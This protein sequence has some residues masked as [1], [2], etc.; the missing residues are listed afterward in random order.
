MTPEA[1]I[2]AAVD[3]LDRVLAGEPAERSLTTWARGNRFAG[4]RD[5]AAIRDHVYDALRRR[6]SALALSGQ[7]TSSGRALMIGLLREDGGDP[8]TVF[9]GQGYAPAP[10]SAQEAE[11]LSSAPVRGDLPEA[12]SLDLPDWLVAPL[13]ARL[14]DDFGAAMEAMRHR[15]PVFLRV[16][17]AR[18][19]RE[20]AAEA[21]AAEGIST[22]HSPLAVHALEVIDGA[23]RI[24]SSQSYL[25]GLVEL[26]DAASQAAVESLPLT[27][28]MRVLDYC[29]GGGGKV[30]AMAAR[31]QGTWFAHDADPR[32]MADLPTRA[33]RAGVAVRRIPTERVAVEAP[34]DLVL[35]DVPCTGSGTWR[36]TPEAKWTLR[37]ERLEELTRTQDDILSDAQALVR[38]GGAL[39][40]MT[41]SLLE[42]EN[43][44]R[45]AAFLMAHPSFE[46]ETERRFSPL[47]GGD[48]FYLAC[49]R[50][51]QAASF[52]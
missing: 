18:S 51:N 14:G 35:T 12:I 11:A 42:Q 1:R 49:L 5:R 32:R 40:Y 10:L 28:G 39:A 34:F 50:R 23:G 20:R 47:D 21:L 16:N 3:I 15:A 27:S 30:L 19:D 33:E 4:S 9:S 46:L 26:Q 7:S 31:A 43:G 13:R 48:G 8:G 29:A 37:P 41:C 24:K 25:T 2:A 52:P 44:D 38:P 45:I 36:R 22:R 17:A 6:R